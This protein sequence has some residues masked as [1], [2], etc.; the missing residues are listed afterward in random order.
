[1]VLLGRHEYAAAL[2]LARKLN[3]LIPDDVLMY[4]FIGDACMALGDY[5]EAEA[6][7]Q[8]MVNMRRT[9][10]PAMIRGACCKYE[11]CNRLSRVIG[12]ATR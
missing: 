2:E 4:G 10:I 3:K 11:T 9:N 12:P 7:I 8:W 1:M 6:K 5:T